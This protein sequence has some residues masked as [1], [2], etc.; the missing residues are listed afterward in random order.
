MYYRKVCHFNLN[1]SG[2]KL[3]HEHFNR[4]F[5]FERERQPI[6][7]M[8]RRRGIHIAE[9]LH[10]NNIM[11][12]SNDDL[13]ALK[14]CCYNDC[15]QEPQNKNSDALLDCQHGRGLSAHNNLSYALQT[16][17]TANKQTHSLAL[18]SFISLRS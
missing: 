1:G 16:A 4:T 12:I 6:I 14:Q 9:T 8:P 11:L 13:S 2:H 7:R 5:R 3:Q 15:T 10:A 18:S 17:N